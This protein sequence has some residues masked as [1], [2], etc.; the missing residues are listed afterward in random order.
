LE[1]S[2]PGLAKMC[3]D[4]VLGGG[5]GGGHARGAP[6]AFGDLDKTG[7]LLAELRTCQHLVA[8]PS[9]RQEPPCPHGIFR[10]VGAQAHAAHG[11]EPR[12]GGNDNQGH[13]PPSTSTVSKLI[14]AWRGESPISFQDL[15][16]TDGPRG[17]KAG[18]H[19]LSTHSQRHI[20][21][22]ILKSL[23]NNTSI[24]PEP[25]V[26]PLIRT[27]ASIVAGSAPNAAMTFMGIPSDPRSTLTNEEW[28]IN[29]QL[30]LGLPLA[31]YHNQPHAL[32]PHGC[33]HPLT[34]EL[35]NVRYCYHLHHVLVTDC[36]KANQGKK[37]H[38]DVEATII[39]HFNTY[40]SITATKAKPFSDG[41]QTSSFRASPPSTIRRPATQLAPRCHVYQSYEG[42]QPGVDQPRRP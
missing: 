2:F 7:D 23:L 41:K 24:L 19:E 39:H 6:T 26:L 37:S 5:Q 1:A 3:T 12:T 22:L 25:A 21:K 40:T 34:K 32:C 42:H 29:T 18:Q 11:R 33:R 13:I 14:A 10:V 16:S 30:Q 8:S 38:K 36:L 31:S 27:H 20:S 4:L 9:C 35:V 17:T 15:E 28:R